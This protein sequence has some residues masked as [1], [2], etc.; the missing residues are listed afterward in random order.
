M[1]SKLATDSDALGGMPLKGSE[2]PS[3]C[4]MAEAIR[5]TGSSTNAVHPRTTTPN[6]SCISMTSNRIAEEDLF[7]EAISLRY[8]R[9]QHK[10][11]QT[12]DAKCVSDIH[13]LYLKQPNSLLTQ[14][15]QGSFR[16][17]KVV[18]K[19][20]GKLC[21]KRT[22]Y[23]CNRALQRRV[24]DH[25]SY[26]YCSKEMDF[27]NESIG[28]SPFC[29]YQTEEEAFSQKYGR[30]LEIDAQPSSVKKSLESNLAIGDCALTYLSVTPRHD[31]TVGKRLFIKPTW[32]ERLFSRL[33]Y[34]KPKYTSL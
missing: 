19:D 25:D 28:L 27:F 8:G 2:L 16:I 7:K 33:C 10:S 26:L 13:L 3:V 12:T 15:T 34:F 1:T 14:P 6:R 5:I 4:F 29:S 9:D 30:T 23:L 21:K 11:E 24:A 20:N 22:L 17:S 32:K 18:Q 31:S